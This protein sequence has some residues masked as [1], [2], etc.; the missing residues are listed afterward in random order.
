[1]A[2]NCA[3]CKKTIRSASIICTKCK[4]P[5]S[6]HMLGSCTTE[7]DRENV[8]LRAGGRKLVPVSQTQARSTSV[9]SDSN[10]LLALTS[11]IKLLRGDSTK[12]NSERLPRPITVRFIRRLKR[13]EFLKAARSRHPISS[14]DLKINGVDRNLYFNERLTQSNRQL[15]RS[16]KLR[17]GELGFRFCWVKNGTILVRKQEGNPSMAI[18]TNEDLDRH[19]A[20]PSPN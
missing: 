3:T 18:R 1:M 9:E 12:E 15:F 7:D 11:E 5:L 19:L 4:H 14:S 16:T 6:P 2:N 10:V 13:D 17:A 20:L 8:P